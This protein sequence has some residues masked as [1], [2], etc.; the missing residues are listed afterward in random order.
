M[1]PRPETCNPPAHMRLWIVLLTGWHATR[2]AVG[3]HNVQLAVRVA[4]S[5]NKPPDLP[6]QRGLLPTA[7][8]INVGQ[9]TLFNP[10]WVPVPST[11]QQ[12][13]SIFLSVS[14]CL[15]CF[16]LTFSQTVV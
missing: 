5:V 11:D 9:T 7:K 6:P 13:L 15:F 2:A 12:D 8:E 4:V 14:S 3:A 10:S 1:E 16:I